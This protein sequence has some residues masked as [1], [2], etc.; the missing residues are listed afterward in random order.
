LLTPAQQAHTPL[1]QFEADGQARD[2]I[3]GRITTCSGAPTQRFSALSFLSNPRSVVYQLTMTRGAAAHGQIA[4]ARD[5]TGWHVADLSA[6]LAGVDL[7]PLHT[8]Q[9]LCAAFMGRKYDVA[10]GLLSTPYQHEQGSEQAFARD[11]GANLAITGCEPALRGYTID[12]TD[13]RASFQIT[14][15]VSVSGGGSATKLTLPATVALVRE[16]VGWRVD[17]ITPSLAQ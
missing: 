11:F 16:Q 8:E 6:A 10:Y 2:T 15:D 3:S 9:A 7:G 13:Q 5:A 12:K 17:A 1:A 14:L 4:L